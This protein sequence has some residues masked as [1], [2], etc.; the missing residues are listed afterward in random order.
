MKATTA[1]YK[2]ILHFK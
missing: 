1:V 2:F